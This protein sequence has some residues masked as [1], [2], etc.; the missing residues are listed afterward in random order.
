MLSVVINKQLD[1]MPSKQR[2]IAMMGYRSV[3]NV[4]NVHLIKYIYASYL[5]L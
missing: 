2:K 4:Y 5:M 3:G 1:K